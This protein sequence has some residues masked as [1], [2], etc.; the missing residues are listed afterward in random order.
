MPNDDSP[1]E[2]VD[3]AAFERDLQR[4][5]DA[6]CDDG[7]PSG[8]APSDPLLDDLLAAWDRLN[9]RADPGAGGDGAMF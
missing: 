8:P 4:W 9:G 1:R 3:W 7:P 5:K 6:S 2:T